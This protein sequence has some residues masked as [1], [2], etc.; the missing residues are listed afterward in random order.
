MPPR[1]VKNAVIPDDRDY[2]CASPKGRADT[3]I[4]D[5]R[6]NVPDKNIE[7]LRIKL[8]RECSILREQYRSLFARLP[9]N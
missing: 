6:A 3:L 7:A 2:H 4:I 1:E 5:A 9:R 8:R